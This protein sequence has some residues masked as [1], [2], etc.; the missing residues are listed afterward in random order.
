MSQFTTFMVCYGFVVGGLAGLFTFRSAKGGLGVAVA[1][2]LAG[3]LTGAV[4]DA[5]EV[6]A[7]KY[8]AISEITDCRMRTPIASALADR[9]L[10]S[11]EYDTLRSRERA[12]DLDSA[13]DEALGTEVAQCATTKARTS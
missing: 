8:K 10:T 12:F 4:M 13:R 7:W 9:R 5:Q 6:A 2:T 1:C 3:L 11:G